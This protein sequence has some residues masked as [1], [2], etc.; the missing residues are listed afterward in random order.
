MHAVAKRNGTMQA[1]K[2]STEPSLQA[3]SAMAHFFLSKT[4]RLIKT[5]S[6]SWPQT[7]YSLRFFW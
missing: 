7:G 6:D 3:F 1:W 2:N 4:R 5:A